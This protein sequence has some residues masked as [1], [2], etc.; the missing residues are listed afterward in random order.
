MV[1]V[2]TSQPTIFTQRM[3]DKGVKPVKPVIGENYSQFR[4]PED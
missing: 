3:I 4:S 1:S 2:M